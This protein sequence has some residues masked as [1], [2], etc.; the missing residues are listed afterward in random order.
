VACGQQILNEMWFWD[1]IIDVANFKD[2]KIKLLSKLRHW[3][4]MA[5]G[6]KKHLPV[7]IHYEICIERLLS[8]E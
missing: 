2:N 7:I 3:Y 1:Q 8:F 4:F 6:K 5:V